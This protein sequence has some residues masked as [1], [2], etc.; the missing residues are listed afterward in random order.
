MEQGSVSIPTHD[1]YFVYLV[2]WPLPRQLFRFAS[3][4]AFPLIL[5]RGGRTLIRRGELERHRRAERP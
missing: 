2:A 3:D 1:S 5:D 4:S